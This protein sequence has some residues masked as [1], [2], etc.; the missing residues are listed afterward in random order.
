MNYAL[1]LLKFAETCP[2]GIASHKNTGMVL[3]ACGNWKLPYLLVINGQSKTND[4][5]S[6]PEI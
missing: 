6:K 1:S 5:F 2:F 4:P 3:I